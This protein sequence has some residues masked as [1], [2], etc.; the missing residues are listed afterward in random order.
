MSVIYIYF[1]YSEPSDIALTWAPNVTAPDHG[2]SEYAECE[3]TRLERTSSAT[4]H[5]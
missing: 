2:S 3:R 5:L 4:E 1:A